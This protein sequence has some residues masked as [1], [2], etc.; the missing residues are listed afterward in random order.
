MPPEP[1]QD[2]GPAMPPPE[3]ILAFLQQMPPEIKAQ[4]QQM[5]PEQQMQAVME[6]YS[7]V[8]GG[9]GSNGIAYQGRDA[10]PQ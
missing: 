9:G 5:P 10:I 2:A 1:P 4:L 7:Q 3:E 8:V 6:L